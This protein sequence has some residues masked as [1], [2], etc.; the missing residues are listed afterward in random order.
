ATGG[1]IFAPGDEAGGVMVG[2]GPAG[3]HWRLRRQCE[4]AR[5]QSVPPCGRA[6]QGAPPPRNGRGGKK[7]NPPDLRRT[8][9]T[10]GPRQ[11][12]RRTAGPEQRRGR[13]ELGR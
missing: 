2:L 4:H 9:P 10:T 11:E 1:R 5:S 3:C 8:S 6:A 7:K 12:R 13:M